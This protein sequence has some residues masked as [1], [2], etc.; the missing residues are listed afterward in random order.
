VAL[1]AIEDETGGREGMKSWQAYALAVL[2]AVVGLGFAPPAAAAPSAPGP[3]VAGTGVV[4]GFPEAIA[5]SANPLSEN[6]RQAFAAAFNAIDA[7]NWP[8]ALAQGALVRNPLAKKIITWAY[9]SAEETKPT[10]DDLVTFANENPEWPLQNALL[11]KAENALPATMPPT[12][13]IAWFAGQEPLTAEGMVRLGEALLTTGETAYG[14]GWIARAWAT[15]AF[16]TRR[17]RELFAAYGQYLKG[18]PSTQRMSLLLWAHEAAM[19]RWLLPQVPDDLKRIAQARIAL[20]EGAANALSLASALPATAQ[21]DAGV[22]FEQ[23]RYL[24]RRGDDDKARRKLLSIEHPEQLPYPDKWWIERHVQ[25]RKAM[26]EK[27]YQDA[28]ALAAKSGLIA[29]NDFAEAEWLA[30]WL[31]L[32]FLDKAQL[33]HRHFTTLEAGVTY[34][35]SLARAE[36]W[37]GRALQDAGDKAGAAAAYAK[38]ARFPNTYYGQLSAE[39]PLLTG[40]TLELP[41]TPSVDKAKFDEFLDNQLVKAIRLIK[42]A[43]EERFVR[44]LAYEIADHAPA[45]EDLILLS[46]LLWTFDQP[47][48]SVR[49]AKKASQ[50]HILLTDYL[51]P[52]FALP[53]YPG[54][55]ARPE[56]ALILG[57]ARQE[58][59]FN[60]RAVSSAGAR[61]LM[62]MLPSTARL[63]ARKHGVPY[64][65]DALL[66]D[67]AYN[68]QLGMAHIGDLLERFDGSY[69]LVIAAY[70]AGAGRVG[71][72]LRKIGDPRNKDVDPV[73][74]I[75]RIP[76][77]E[78]RNYVQRVLENTLVYRH[79]IARAPIPFTLAKELRRSSAMPVDIG[80]TARKIQPK[81]PVN[82]PAP[83]DTIAPT[84][85]GS[86]ETLPEPEIVDREADS[87]SAPS[88]AVA[89][90]PPRPEELD[91]APGS[92]GPALP[93]GAS[94]PAEDM[95]PTTQIPPDCKTF[96]VRPNGATECVD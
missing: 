56:P 10:F 29:G 20:M 28:Y 54:A 23:V 13:L 81:G 83:I 76:F 88:R 68:M 64:R 44:T 41:P 49:I 31:A 70:N 17:Q 93:A 73:D 87:D 36:Y 62:Q 11:A 96:I 48:I 15:Q 3:V 16:D 69:V 92:A 57:L 84:D 40:Q 37:I 6:D 77:T 52:V 7:R 94:Q 91:R 75:E 2:M 25:A 86:P 78:T 22:L 72:W 19:A 50:R 55:G 39:S 51:Y 5:K 82:P 8:R 45:N 27:E 14:A 4:P 21:A 1:F 46:E 38:A 60:P 67:P 66:K 53:T 80:Y 47:A 89:A 90:V 79:R 18:R 9:L 95:P 58:S 59:E 26:E 85:E 61:G 35:I 32:R 33:A 63:T 12:R 43:K 74:W 42:E 65:Q 24:R 30:G 71:E 34:P